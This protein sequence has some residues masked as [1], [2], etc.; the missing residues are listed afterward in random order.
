MESNAVRGPSFKSIDLAVYAFLLVMGIF[1]FTH[2]PHFSDF[3]SDVTYPD[4]A[5]SILHHGTYQIRLMPET[6]F[7]PGFPVILAG[8]GLL[9]GLTPMALFGVVAVSTTLGLLVSYEFLRRLEGRALAVAVALILG[10]SAA[11]FAFNTVI[12]YPEMTY[13]LAS[14]LA[15]WL[16]W[17]IDRT[18]KSRLLVVQIALLGVLIAAALLV[19]S[20]GVALLAGLVSW[21]AAS[22]FFARKTGC[23]RLR[24][25]AFPLLLGIVAQLSWSVWAHHHQEYEWNLPGYPR[26]YISQV[27]VKD[28]NHPEL[29]VARLSDIP[30]RVG[31][32][33]VRR[34]AGLSALLTTRGVAKFWSSPGIVFP[35]FLIVI[36]VGSSLRGGGQLHDWYYLWYEVIFMLWPW[37][38]ADRFLIPAVPL[39]CL[40]LWRGGR[41]AVIFAADKP[42]GAGVILLL[43]GSILAA[44]SAAFALGMA[45]FE[46]NPDHVR[47]DNLQTIAAIM[48]WAFA[49]VLGLAMLTWDSWKR[50]LPRGTEPAPSGGASKREYWRVAGV[51]ASIV[52]FVIVAGSV[53]RVIAIGRNNMHPQVAPENAE[54]LAAADWIR[55]HEPADWVILAGEPEFL[56][57]FTDHRTIW[58]APISDAKTLMDGIRRYHVRVVVVTYQ[59]PSYW[60]PPEDICFQSLLNA[61]GSSFQLADQGPGYWVYNVEDARSKQAHADAVNSRPHRDRA[62]RMVRSHEPGKAA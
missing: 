40:Y 49:A 2:Y 19:R 10:S 60:Q 53:K 42:R 12:V 35:I 6:T 11:M 22:V 29:G 52:L 54:M 20:V 17:K 57:H 34:A 47:G 3:M 15:L 50:L 51:A 4:L 26:S 1:Q 55:A 24:R 5:K 16:A 7:P 36:G 59:R 62:D 28:G 13:I 46:V 21:L 18:E 44:V 39:A 41:Q 9:G 23:R 58:F 61:Y 37:N 38:Y 8:V 30:G 43:G 31:R 32:N 48:L 45:G 33:L 27:A 14:M 25:F 56:Y